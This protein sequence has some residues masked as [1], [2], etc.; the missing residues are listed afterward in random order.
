MSSQVNQLTSIGTE[1]ND[2]TSLR[3]IMVPEMPLYAI[4]ITID[5]LSDEISEAMVNSDADERCRT[6]TRLQDKTSIFSLHTAQIIDSIIVFL[7][8]PAVEAR[9]TVVNSDTE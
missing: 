4:A 3:G 7:D 9:E 8:K 6:G 5:K 1:L 2:G